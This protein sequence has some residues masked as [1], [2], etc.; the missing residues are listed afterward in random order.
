MLPGVESTPEQVIN[1][2]L[3]LLVRVHPYLTS[4]APLPANVTTP[5]L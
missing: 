1:Q 4:P 2:T 5:P 3:R